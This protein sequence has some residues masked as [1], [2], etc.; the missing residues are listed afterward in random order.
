M[1]YPLTIW[2]QPIQESKSIY[3]PSDRPIEYIR[4]DMYDE[5]LKAFINLN[6][7]AQKRAIK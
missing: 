2:H 1:Q 7:E 6:E 5:I 3:S 4:K